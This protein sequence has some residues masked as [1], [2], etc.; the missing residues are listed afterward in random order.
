MPLNLTTVVSAGDLDPNASNYS[1]IKVIDIRISPGSKRL[2]FSVQMGNTGEGGVWVPGIAS[3]ATF[4]L[5]AA[6]FDA[7][8]THVSND[9]ELTYDAMARGIYEWLVSGGH[10][11]GTVS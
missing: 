6:E 9:G 2:E 4:R 3:L 1:K 7:A 10:Y 11:A 5:T 8:K